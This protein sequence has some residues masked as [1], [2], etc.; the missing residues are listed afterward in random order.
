M[1][2][3]PLPATPAW[4]NGQHIGVQGPVKVGEGGPQLAAKDLHESLQSDLRSA[5]FEVVPSPAGD[6]LRLVLDTFERMGT[7]VVG[8]GSVL[9]ASLWRGQREVDRF[10]VTADQL[11]CVSPLWG[12]SASQNADCFSRGLRRALL[13][14]EKLAAAA[15][16]APATPRAVSYAAA[17]GQARRPRSERTSP[18]TR[19][20]R[21]RSTSPM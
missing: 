15:A 2:A 18:R 11:G 10:E 8:G 6:E 9:K 5:G 1:H 4:L 3:A 20:R 21:T 14:S 7:G 16:G 19:P 13:R 17:Q 12:V